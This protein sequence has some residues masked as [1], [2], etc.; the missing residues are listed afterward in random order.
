METEAKERKSR[1]FNLL[2]L[3]A[4]LSGSLLIVASYAWF[5]ASL[6]VKIRFFNM[7]VSDESG[8]FVSLDGVNFASST[9]ISR[10]AVVKDLK[11][12]YPNHTNQWA[13]GGLYPTSSN[14][15]SSSDNN[16][17]DMYG[18]SIIE[19]KYPNYTKRYLNTSLMT[20]DNPSDYNLFISFDLFLKNVSGSPY[21]DNLYLHDGT[22][23]YFNEAESD[24]ADGTINSIR[25]G[26][27]KI[28][29][30]SSKSDIKTIQNLS[31][32]GNCESLIYEPN[33]YKHS[34]DS[35]SRARAY[36]IDLANGE[37]RSTYGVIG[38]GEFL[39]M[40]NGHEE[41]NIAL[42]EKHFAL[43]KTFTNFDEPM[44][45]L[46]NGITKLRVYVW[47]EGQDIDSL[48]TVAK[49]AGIS[50]VINFYKDL[51]GLY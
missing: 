17:F 42:D 38:E 32:E 27:V 12:L 19:Y 39:E 44:Y 21:P 18:S 11:K 46:P 9:E 50:I 8:L 40:A 3:V 45:T 25:F 28:C 33:A 13:Y 29:S 31:C 49:G 30:T 47:L 24:D 6:D 36:G 43:Q 20:E 51:A 1:N 34:E 26:F 4:F 10:D 22:D 14:G 41:S 23:V 35:I 2:L 37:Y 7:I 16:K 15:I 48:E 5:N